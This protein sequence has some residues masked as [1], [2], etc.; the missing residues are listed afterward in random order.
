VTGKPIPVMQQS[1]RDKINDSYIDEL[2]A[3]YVEELQ[4]LWD[5]WKDVYAKDR[6]GELEIIA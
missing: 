2:H 1:N 6:T 3:K 4:R 5:Q